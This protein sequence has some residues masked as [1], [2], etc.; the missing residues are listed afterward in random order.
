MTLLAQI[1]M[2]PITP[3]APRQL[4]TISLLFTKIEIP[5]LLIEL[6]QNPPRI[7]SMVHLDENELI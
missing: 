2:H 7:D 3:L 1:F 4:S 6:G 5:L